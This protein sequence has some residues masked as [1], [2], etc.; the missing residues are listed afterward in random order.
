MSEENTVPVTCERCGTQLNTGSGFRWNWKLEHVCERC[1]RELELAQRD[2][3]DS[4]SQISHDPVHHPSHYV[5]GGIETIDYIRSRL[6]HAEYI[7]Y[8]TGN[9]HKY[10][11]RYPHKGGAEDLRKMRQYLEW[12]IEAV[13][14]RDSVLDPRD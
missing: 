4:K 5:Q 14:S 12:L 10:L 9:C 2:E 6:S 13:D 3:N 7:G 1:F 11:S 8:L